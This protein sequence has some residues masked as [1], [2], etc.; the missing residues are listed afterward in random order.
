MRTVDHQIAFSC[1]E[2]AAGGKNGFFISAMSQTF[3]SSFT[4]SFG[5]QSS[6]NVGV[7]IVILPSI[8]FAWMKGAVFF[9]C[10]RSPAGNERF[11]DVPPPSRQIDYLPWEAVSIDERG[12]FS[13]GHL[14]LSGSPRKA[15]ARS[16][17]GCRCEPK[18]SGPDRDQHRAT[19][20][21]LAGAQRNGRQGCPFR[22]RSLG[23]INASTGLG[24]QNHVNLLFSK[25]VPVRFNGYRPNH[26][27]V[28]LELHT[29]GIAHFRR[30]QILVF[31][32][33]EEM[34]PKGMPEVV[35]RPFLDHRW[36]P[37]VFSL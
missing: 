6:K 13:F 35:V 5:V 34:R 12:G 30:R 8:K 15:E 17:A 23:Q 21:P 11:S 26:G 24:H 3:T 19:W 4:S 29:R 20:V 14:N 2:M 33:T 22:D 9:A 10:Y 28:M 16:P 32:R 36:H 7:L 27:P 31:D 37:W 1:A 18:R 25:D